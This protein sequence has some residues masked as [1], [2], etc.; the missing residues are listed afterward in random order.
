[1]DNK[2]IKIK[3]V[4]T[5]R[6]LVIIMWVLLIVSIVFGIFNNINS[7]T[8]VV[9]NETVVTV[10]KV[11]D[12]NGVWVFVRNF[13]RVYYAWDNSSESVLKRES[14]V[15]EY[16]T[17]ELQV[18]NKGCVREDVPVKS[19]VSDMQIWS[20]EDVTD[21]VDETVTGSD[22]DVVYT[23][24]QA[25]TEKDETKKVSS[26]YRVR[27]HEDDNGDMVIMKSPTICSVPGVSDYQPQGLASDGSVDATIRND[28]LGFLETFF[29]L[30]PEATE[31]ELS[32][33]V[34]NNAL[35]P[36]DGGYVFSEIVNPVMVMEDDNVIRVTLAVKYLDS[37]T[38][39]TQ[40]SQFDLRIAKDGGNWVIVR[41]D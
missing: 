14:A 41:S 7:K 36:I 39:M 23:V 20:I 34:R 29:K 12:T 1:M 3:R 5:R 2:R 16:F 40:V 35:E 10:E 31:S 24:V 9:N 25:I 37:Y 21:Y 6:V 13:I 32:Y 8:T 17:P 15:N 22:Y 33:Y 27:V 11:N 4:G 28:A 19:V 38:K 30:Y 26:A 18:L